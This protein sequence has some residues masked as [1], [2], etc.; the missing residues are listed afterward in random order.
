MKGLDL[1]GYTRAENISAGATNIAHAM[2]L[3]IG[4]KPNLATVYSSIDYTL[5]IGTE[6]AV[7]QLINVEGKIVYS[8]NITGKI[9]QITLDIRRYNSGAYI[10]KI[11]TDDYSLSKSFIIQ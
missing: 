2:G 5:P 9:G 8:E 6:H 1:Y 11:Q 10:I 3:S 4:I 7:L